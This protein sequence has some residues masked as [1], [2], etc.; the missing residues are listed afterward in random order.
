MAGLLLFTQQDNNGHDVIARFASSLLRQK[1]PQDTG[2]ARMGHPAAPG[3]KEGPPGDGPGGQR[4]E[5][6]P[7]GQSKNGGGG[8]PA[9][10]GAADEAK[11]T[12]EEP[13]EK[14]GGP[15]MPAEQGHPAGPVG[16][17]GGAGGKIEKDNGA[18]GR[19]PRPVL[20]RAESAGDGGAVPEHNWPPELQKKVEEEAWRRR[21][22][23]GRWSVV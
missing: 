6:D 14:G 11:E 23:T 7:G 10:L 12:E 15:E 13:G 2:H 5:G 21:K 9:Q 18:T 22:N 16:Q 20:K 1:R 17:E 3:H 8:P 4:S 19:P